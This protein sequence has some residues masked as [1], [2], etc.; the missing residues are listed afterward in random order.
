MSGDADRGLRDIEWV[1]DRSRTQFPSNVS[2][3]FEELDKVVKEA[4]AKDKMSI[5]IAPAAIPPDSIVTLKVSFKNFL[6]ITVVQT[7]TFTISFIPVPF[8]QV[9]PAE[10]F[11]Y[12]SSQNLM[13]FAKG[14]FVQCATEGS[15]FFGFLNDVL[16]YKWSLISS[17]AD[18]PSSFDPAVFT[19]N[20]TKHRIMSLPMNTLPPGHTFKFQAEIWS[21]SHPEILNS[22]VV[23][24]RTL[25]SPLVAVIAD[26][27][28]AVCASE[29]LL[30]NGSLSLDPDGGFVEAC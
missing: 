3:S 19:N 21:A 24:L 26:G 27:S 18:L 16:F 7:M 28:R 14:G 4:I 29:S 30:L 17:T 23:T 12:L 5:S 10:S 8:L 22:K 13:I 6:N 20:Q 15:R 2:Y 11:E 25:F 9:L 1:V